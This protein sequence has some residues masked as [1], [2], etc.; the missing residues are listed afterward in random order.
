[1]IPV[2]RFFF[3]IM[4]GKLISFFSPILPKN[5]SSTVKVTYAKTLYRDINKDY[6]K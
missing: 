6:V 2:L 1:M 5:L 3:V 4:T